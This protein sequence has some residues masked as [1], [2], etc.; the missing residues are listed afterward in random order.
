LVWADTVL[1]AE[2][3]YVALIL[4]WAALSVLAATSLAVILAVRR[5]KS[6]ILAH[7]AVQLG[8]WGLVLGLVGAL[9]WQGLHLRDLA[10]ATRLERATW[11]RVGFDVGVVGMGAILAGASR[12]FGRNLAAMGAAAG[13][14]VQGAALLVIDL[15][16]A[17]VVSR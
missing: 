17:S 8:G 7:F 3:Q 6:P 16:L 2:R 11:A 9:E 13:L 1:S 5:I 10:G 12:W 14:A 15:Q 4:V